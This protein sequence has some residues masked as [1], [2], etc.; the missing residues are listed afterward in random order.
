MQLGDV[1]RCYSRNT[2]AK[3]LHGIGPEFCESIDD[4]IPINEERLRTSSDVESDSNE[5]VDLDQAGDEAE[6]GD[7]MED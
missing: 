6:G 1:E 7:V 5:E 2:H 4:V 3:S